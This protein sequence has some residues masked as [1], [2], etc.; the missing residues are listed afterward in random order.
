MRSTQICSIDFSLCFLRTAKG[1]L[2]NKGMRIKVKMAENKMLN[3]ANKPISCNAGAETI[4][5]PK[6]AVAV[7]AALMMIGSLTSCSVCLMEP[8]F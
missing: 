5:K 2:R 3:P 8:P 7:V 1:F 6:K 4:Y